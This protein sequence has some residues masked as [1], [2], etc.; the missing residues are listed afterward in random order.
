MSTSPPFVNHAVAPAI[1]GR[2][3]RTPVG[4]DARAS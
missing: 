2:R 1:P 3:P 4:V